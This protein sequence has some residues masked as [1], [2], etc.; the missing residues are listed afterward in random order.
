VRVWA[1]L[2]IILLIVPVFAFEV[3]PANVSD[4]ELQKIIMN[5]PPDEVK[6]SF[7]ELPLWIK[8]HH[9][10]TIVLSMIALL[11][12]LPFVITKLKTALENRKRVKILEFIRLNQG[13]SI[14]QLQN[15]LGI[16]RSTLKYHLSILER[17]GLISTIKVGNKRL[18]FAGEPEDKAL[19]SVKT[20][21]RK[22]Q[23]LD[24]L[25]E[26]DGLKLKEIS[27]KMNLNFKLLYYHIKELEKL[28]LVSVQK[29]K[30]YLNENAKINRK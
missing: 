17:E 18:I 3:R 30:V 15:E 20:S 12:L 21:E 7:W 16:N 11:K 29:G 24:F 27:E 8:I 9:L 14:T 5:D 28:G 25:Y 4:E 10:L 13:T 1:A 19:L 2:L 22:K 26:T 23:I 6:V